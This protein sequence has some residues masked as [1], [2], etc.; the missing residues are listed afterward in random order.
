MKAVLFDLSDTLYRNE[1]LEEQYPEQLHLLLARD[2]GLTIEEAKAFM[3][4][5][6]KGLEEKTGRHITK[7]AV[8]QELGYTRAQVHEEFCRVD[9]EKFL[10]PDS[11]L[12]EL[13][14]RLSRHYRLGMITNLR[15]IQVLKTLN[16]LGVNPALF[17]VLIGEDDV[18]EIKP[19][20][21]PFKKALKLLAESPGNCAYVADSVDKDLKPA[22]IV[23]MKTILVGGKEGNPGCVDAVIESILDLEKALPV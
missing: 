15:K 13:M 16:A 21:E 23:G 1:E 17:E 19:N 7:V 3:K 2:K 14:E 4:K 12:A 6:K 8:M 9:P 20:I 11:Q 22:K 10:R 5:T 18:K